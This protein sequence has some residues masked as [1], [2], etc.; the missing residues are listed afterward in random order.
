MFFDEFLEFNSFTNE[1]KKFFFKR[2]KVGKIKY[3]FFIRIREGVKI[4]FN[5]LFIFYFHG[6]NIFI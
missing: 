5:F 1:K 6:Q 4:M 2:L 3:T